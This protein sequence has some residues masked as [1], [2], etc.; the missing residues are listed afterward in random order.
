MYNNQLGGVLPSAWKSMTAL[1]H[2]DLSNNTG[3]SGSLPSEWASLT[4]L[5]EL[6]LQN[7]GSVAGTVPLEWNNMTALTKLDISRNPGLTGEIPELLHNKFLIGELVLSDDGTSLVP[8]TKPERKCKHGLDLY[9]PYLVRTLGPGNNLN[10]ECG[11]KWGQGP[12]NGTIPEWIGAVTGLTKLV[13]YRNRM[14][15]TLPTGLGLL[16]NM[17]TL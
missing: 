9:L 13:V 8:P 5:S 7:V 17:H 16:T 1:K 12:V 2:L 6:K 15:G 4:T 3:V 10:V 11:P 14:V